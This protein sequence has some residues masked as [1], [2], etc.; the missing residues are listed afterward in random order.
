MSKLTLTKE[1]WEEDKKNIKLDKKEIDKLIYEY[2]I[3]EGHL[4]AAEM[5]QKESNTKSL[6]NFI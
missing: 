1:T 3:I 6:F 5:F 2:F 4:E